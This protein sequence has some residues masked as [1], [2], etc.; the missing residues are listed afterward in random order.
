M[1]FG[2]ERIGSREATRLARGV[3]IRPGTVNDEFAA[4]DVMR[5]A[6]GFEM[7]WTHH[8]A[9]RQH[10]RTQPGSSFWIAEETARFGPSKLIGYAASSVR[11]GV[12][13]LTEFFV[14]PGS[15][16]Q[17][18]GHALLD[19]CLAD[20][21]A[22]NAQT[23]LVLAS[24][25]YGA[26]SL[27][28]RKLGCFPRLPMLL[29]SGSIADLRPPPFGAPRVVE[30]SPALAP[31]TGPVL[32]DVSPV[33]ASETLFAEPLVLTP[34]VQAE[35]DALDRA[36][37]GYA[38]PQEHAHWA[39]AMGRAARLFR[40]EGPGGRGQGPENTSDTFD[41][42][43]NPKSKIE[44]PL[45]GYAYLGAHASGPALATEPSYL[46]A[47]LAHI[48]GVFRGQHPEIGNAPFA[49][50]LD[51]YWSLAGTNEVM[52]KWLLDCGWR[53]AFHY[54]LM[55]TGPVGQLDR[56]VCYNPLYLL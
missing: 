31:V 16:R 1:A 6:M 36:I 7:L 12:W 24:H 20:A 34:S 56:Y 2:L 50:L 37:V 35:I 19:A 22:C 49:P 9:M 42:I 54:L 41:V 11:E 33:R 23:K 18:V 43:Q 8:A 3:R 48:A 51:H 10:L 46:P 5:R 13:A 17:G 27:Y 29:L 14:L 38:R 26:D 21:P 30:A 15:Q 53:I 45:V 25:H 55:S 28:I 39:G 52:L 32:F 44:N 40:R 4:F 47:M